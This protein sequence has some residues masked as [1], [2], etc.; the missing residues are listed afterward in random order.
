MKL[1]DGDNVLYHYF[2]QVLNAEDAESRTLLRKLLNNLSIWLPVELYQKL[3]VLLPFVVRDPWCR[4]AVNK[5]AEEWGTCNADGYFRDDN[6]LIKPIPRP[7]KIRGKSPTYNNCKLGRGFVASHLWRVVLDSSKRAS[8]DPYLNS[9][10]PNL[11]WLPRQIS[12]FTDREGS[13]AQKYLQAL[14]YAIYH[15][16]KQIQKKM[17]S[18]TKSGTD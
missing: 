6:S 7:F 5:T 2:K 17:N 1:L 4:E 11:T 14:S 15:D 16:V 13:F 9:F 8:E 18:L 10:I 3:P 12:K